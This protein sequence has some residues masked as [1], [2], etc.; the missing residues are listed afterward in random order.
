MQSYTIRVQQLPVV[1]ERRQVTQE[2]TAMKLHKVSA[3][4]IIN[5]PATLVYNILADYRD[6]HPHILPKPFFKSL[7]VLEGGIGEG[8]RIRFQ[9]EAFGKT[10]TFNSVI[11]EPDPG[12]W[13]VEHDQQQQTT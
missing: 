11:T 7:E 9:T 8:T 12:R 3:S 1:C 4:T 13:L 6:G 2:T 5:A 10:Q